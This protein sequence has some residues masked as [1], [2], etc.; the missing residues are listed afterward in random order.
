MAIRRRSVVIDLMGEDSSND[1]PEPI[2]PKLHTPKTASRVP[3]SPEGA[4]FLNDLSNYLPVGSLVLGEVTDSELAWE[5]V[6][7]TAILAGVSNQST[8]NIEKLLT[9][10]RLRLFVSLPSKSVLRVYILPSDVGHRFGF[11]QRDRGTDVHLFSLLQDID[12]SLDSWNGQP[13]VKEPFDL[14]AAGEEGSLYYLFNNIPS[15]DPTSERISSHFHREVMVDLLDT[16]YQ[17]HGLKTVLYPYQRRSA[18]LMLQRECEDR[19]ELDPRLEKRVALD[20]TSYYYDP[21]EVEFVR[22][23]RF[24]ESCKSGILAETMFVS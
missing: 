6:H 14:Y 1:E 24:Y 5:E 7:N 20:A 2:I 17:L 18:A 21:W 15:P 16:Q 8:L 13:K 22:G 9:R 19:L 23:P 4:V 12:V 3:T 11:S 10:R